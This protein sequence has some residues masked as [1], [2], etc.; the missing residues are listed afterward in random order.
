[1]REA[2]TLQGMVFI[3]NE[4]TIPPLDTA[5]HEAYHAWKGTSARTDYTDT[6]RENLD[7]GSREFLTYQQKIAEAYFG[8]DVDVSDVAQLRK[9]E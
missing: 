3:S 8:G 4:T 9:F 7:Y 5:G 1:M 6:V 2:A